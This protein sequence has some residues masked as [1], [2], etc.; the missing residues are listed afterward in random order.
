MSDRSSTASGNLRIS[1]AIQGSVP[2]SELTPGGRA[3]E[4][5][6]LEGA[7]RFAWAAGVGPGQHTGSAPGA[8]LLL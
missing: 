2:R 6:G 1:G 8:D 4:R 3:G 5:E 7:H